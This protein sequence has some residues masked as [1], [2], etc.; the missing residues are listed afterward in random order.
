M[1]DSINHLEKIIEKFEGELLQDWLKTL[2][3][4][5]VRR[6]AS[7]ERELERLSLQFLRAV[8]AAVGK[9]QDIESRMWE[10][11]RALLTELS[12]IGVKKGLSPIETASFVFALK[13]P[14]F[15]RL[16]EEL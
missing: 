1:S 6:D 4:I 16:R 9:S 11:P 7:T 10:E 13:Q 14:L 2:L 15:T 3:T 12:Q 8:R 5:L